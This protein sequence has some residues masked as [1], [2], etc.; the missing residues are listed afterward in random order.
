MLAFGQGNL[1]FNQVVN[2]SLAGTFSTATVMGT[3]TVPAGKVW[4]LENTSYTS[5]ATTYKNVQTGSQ[6]SI[7]I[8]DYLVYHTFNRSQLLPLWLSEGTYSVTANDGNGGLMTFA[9]AAIEFN[10]IP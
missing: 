8:D 2:G 4:K 5:G 10:V 9:Y 1:Q 6:Y 7:W 3:I